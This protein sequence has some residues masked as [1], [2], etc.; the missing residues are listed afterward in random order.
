MG[1]DT[2][3]LI[4]IHENNHQAHGSF[5]SSNEGLIVRIDNLFL[6]LPHPDSDH[7]LTS[8]LDWLFC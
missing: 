5:T 1:Y 7:E 8:Y 3:E 6:L 2:N 4:N